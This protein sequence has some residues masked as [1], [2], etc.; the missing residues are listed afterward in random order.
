[1]RRADGRVPASE[2]PMVFLEFG[3]LGGLTVPQQL[4]TYIS[5]CVLKNESADWST[6]CRPE[7][8]AVAACADAKSVHPY[9]SYLTV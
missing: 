2:Y 8:R 5:Q 6:I 7:G 3:V 1:M 9:L 4:K